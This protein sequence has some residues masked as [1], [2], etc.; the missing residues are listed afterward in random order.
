MKELVITSLKRWAIVCLV[1]CFPGFQLYAQNLAVYGTVRS[2][3]NEPIPGASVLIKGTSQGTITDVD[4]KFKIN[5][6]SP[7]FTLNFS[8]IGY[9]SQDIKI[10]EKRVF[11]VVLER[12][13]KRH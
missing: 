2:S 6:N 10:G 4:G 12:R 9:K 7:E 13:F 8:F 11:N 5:V 3:Q 1:L